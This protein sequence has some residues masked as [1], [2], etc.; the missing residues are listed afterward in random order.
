MWRCIRL[1]T[2]EKI[3]YCY[4]DIDNDRRLY[5]MAADAIGRMGRSV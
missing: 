3:K 1:A 5:G 2:Q 4:I